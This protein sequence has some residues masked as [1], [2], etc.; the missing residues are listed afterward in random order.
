VDADK[1]CQS[2]HSLKGSTV[3]FEV[4]CPDS[5]STGEI[6]YKDEAMNG[7]ITSQSDEGDVT[8]EISGEYQGPCE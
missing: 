7:I 4:T 2:T 3:K 1:D 5:H 6:I 8:I